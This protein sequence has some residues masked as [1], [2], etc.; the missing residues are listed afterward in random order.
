MDE[1]AVRAGKRNAITATDVFRAAHKRAEKSKSSEHIRHANFCRMEV[2]AAIEKLEDLIRIPNVDDL[3][4]LREAHRSAVSVLEGRKNL[5]LPTGGDEDGEDGGGSQ[6]SAEDGER[7][8]PS[9][10]HHF[11]SAK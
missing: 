7:G 4:G 1:R 9:A 3:G 11:E 5:T 2:E 8:G 6:E 10:L